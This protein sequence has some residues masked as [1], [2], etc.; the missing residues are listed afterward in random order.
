MSWSPELY[1]KSLREFLGGASS[2]KTLLENATINVGLGV[3]FAMG[4]IIM[5]LVHRNQL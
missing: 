2:Q 1:W 5:Y 3:L 4:G